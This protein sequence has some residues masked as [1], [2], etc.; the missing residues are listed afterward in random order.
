MKRNKVLKS[1]LSKEARNFFFAI[2]FS[3][4]HVPIILHIKSLKVNFAVFQRI[5]NDIGRRAGPGYSWLN[6]NILGISI[7][8]WIGLY[9]EVKIF[10]IFVFP[11]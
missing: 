2:R 3:I 8:Q 9:N 7:F 4:N 6:L 11:N 5:E 10:I 1:F